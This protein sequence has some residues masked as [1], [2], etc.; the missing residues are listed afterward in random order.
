MY[1]QNKLD[2]LRVSFVWSFPK[3]AKSILEVK[4]EFSLSSSV[5]SSF[6]FFISCFFSLSLT[7]LIESCISLRLT[8]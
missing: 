7:L 1:T 5:I 3:V 6:S 4:Y 2:D 8:L